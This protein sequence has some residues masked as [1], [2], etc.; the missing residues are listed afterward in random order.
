VMNNVEVP[1][2]NTYYYYGYAH[3]SGYR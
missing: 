3:K 1:K 2:G